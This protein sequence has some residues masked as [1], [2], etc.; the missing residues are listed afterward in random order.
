MQ[1][2]DFL[3]NSVLLAVAAELRTNS[4]QALVR[5]HNWDKYDFGSGPTVTDRLNQGPFPQYQPDA[6]IPNDDVVMTTTPSEEVVTNYGKGLVTYITADMGTEEIKADDVSKE[7]ERLV[8]FPLTQQLYIRPTWREIQPRPGRLDLPEYLNLVLDLAKK[9]NKRV[10]L[11]V[12]M[13]A[14]DYTH[15]AALPDFVLDKVPRV[16]LVLSDKENSAAAERY[17]RNPHAR[18]QPRFDHPVF[19]QAFK[20]LIGLLAAEFNG[21]PIIEFIDTFM[22]GF[23]GEGHTWPFANNPFPDY[24]IAERTW[25]NMLEVQLEHFTRTP[26][27]TNT[28]P[29]YSG[30]GNSEV[31]DRTVRSNNWIRS[32]TIFIEN[33]QIEALSNRPPWIA[34]LLEQG[35][36][37]EPPHAAATQEGISPAENMIAHVMDIGANYWSLWNFHHISA[38]NLTSPD[39][40][41]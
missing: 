21:S 1:R 7:I 20:E 22:Y 4:A 27:L 8:R 41:L 6:A 31:L 17:L 2:R 5:A 15:E 18:Y 36:P 26:L 40:L 34:A 24:Q 11:R 33:E 29:D 35:L 30:V 28:Q 23:W 32:D 9:N 38:K 16:D 12:Q 19:Q 13:S 37:G 3:K 14:P 10:G 39:E 25:I